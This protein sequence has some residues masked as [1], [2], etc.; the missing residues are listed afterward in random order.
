MV[1]S[2]EE[3]YTF[4]SILG[5]QAI[6]SIRSPW[7]A[8]EHFP[9]CTGINAGGPEHDLGDDKDTCL[10]SPPWSLSGGRMLA[11]PHCLTRLSGSGARLWATSP[12]SRG[13][14]STE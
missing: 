5:T 3:L 14:A 2:P 7:P 11:N 1:F 4:L 10:H 9:E 6:L 13:T 12:E 8:T